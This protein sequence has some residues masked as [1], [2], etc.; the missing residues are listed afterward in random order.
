MLRMPK[1]RAVRWML[2]GG[3]AAVAL[4]V[5]LWIGLPRRPHDQT[6]NIGADSGGEAPGFERKNIHAMDVHKLK[7]YIT[8]C[9]SARDLQECERA[10]KR[11]IRLTRDDPL[12]HDDFIQLQFGL[13]GLYLN[14]LWEYGQF[15]SEET[16]PPALKRAI[17]IYDNIIAAYPD[18][19]W[20][21]EAQFRR[22][23]VFHNEFSGYWNAL[24]R[25][26]AIREFREVVER[27]PGTPQARRAEQMLIALQDE[28]RG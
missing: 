12:R 5:A 3:S 21:A 27:Y 23:Q 17:D 13:A 25:D 19:A 7:T 16:T 2:W 8:A 24:H 1:T 26:D 20:A 4:M 9:E 15:G 14:S 11:A 18:T 6:S 22:A 10:Y 28:G